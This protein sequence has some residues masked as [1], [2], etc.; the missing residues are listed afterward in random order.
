[1]TTSKTVSYG[2]QGILAP[3]LCVVFGDIRSNRLNSK[4]PPIFQTGRCLYEGMG[5][6]YSPID[7]SRHR[8]PNHPIGA[9]ATLDQHESQA[10]PCSDQARERTRGVTFVDKAGI[11]LLQSLQVRGFIAQLLSSSSLEL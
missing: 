6:Y 10:S 8:W 4:C 9:V 1:M 2:L 5:R 7:P 11:A 3:K